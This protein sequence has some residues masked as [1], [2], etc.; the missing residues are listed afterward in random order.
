[1]AASFVVKEPMT[2][3]SE[4]KIQFNTCIEALKN[5]RFQTVA[6]IWARDMPAGRM[7]LTRSTMQAA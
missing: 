3:E 6:S 7:M 2:V 4:L 5:L 1:M